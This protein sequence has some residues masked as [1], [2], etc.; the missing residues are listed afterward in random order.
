MNPEA[1]RDITGPTGGYTEV[2][3]SAADLGPATERIADELNKQYTIGY[4][5]SRP[6]DGTWRAIRVRI[7]GQP[8]LVRVRARDT[9]RSGKPR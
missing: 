4:A 6:P 3:T 1:L 5:P 2:V 8:Y 9:W 7:K